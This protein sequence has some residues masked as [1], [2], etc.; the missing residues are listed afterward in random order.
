LNQAKGVLDIHAGVSAG[1]SLPH[2]REQG[3]QIELLGELAGLTE[4]RVGGGPIAGGEVSGPEAA[5]YVAGP[6]GPGLGSIDEQRL[7]VALNRPPQVLPPIPRRQIKIGVAQIIEHSGL[8]HR[9][10]IDL[11]SSAHALQNL[12]T[13]GGQM[14]LTLQTTQ[15]FS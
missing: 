10:A 2:L 9:M 6:L 14:G 1:L 8:K 15:D 13:L 3:V 12:H 7:L 11:R 4:G 5:G